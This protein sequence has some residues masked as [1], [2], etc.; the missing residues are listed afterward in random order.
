MSKVLNCSGEIWFIDF[1]T[2]LGI[3]RDNELLPWDRDI[4]IGIIYTSEESIERIIDKLNSVC[5]KY[6]GAN[7]YENQRTLLKFS[8]KSIPIDVHLYFREKNKL[9]CYLHT[10][11]NQKK[12][13]Q[14]VW[15]KVVN[16]AYCDLIDE[17]IL[18]DFHNIPLY[19]PKN[20]N[21]ILVNKYGETWEIK[22]ENW[23]TAMNP[24]IVSTDFRGLTIYGRN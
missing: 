17:V 1:G 12:I 9:I 10:A 3:Y 8:Y 22:N 24:N 4:D 11:I 18:F 16:K 15:D 21:E 6:I 7:Y 13:K 5:I 14:G 19:I 23:K 20:V 2:L